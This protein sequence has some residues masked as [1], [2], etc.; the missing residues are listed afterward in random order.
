MLT[1][2]QRVLLVAGWVMA[3]AVTSLVASAAVAVAGGQVND[4][5]LTKVL[6][7]DVAALPVVD[8]EGDPCNE[9]LASGGFECTTESPSAG[10]QDGPGSGHEPDLVGG[11][12][13]NEAADLVGLDPEFPDGVTPAID[14]GGPEEAGPRF[15]I[16]TATEVITIGGG[17]VSFAVQDGIIRVLWAIPQYGYTTTFDRS[18]PTAPRI[19]FARGDLKNGAVAR[20]ED[21][22][23]VVD[24]FESDSGP[25][26]R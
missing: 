16:P 1:M 3:A 9:P 11:E 13:D 21:D 12:E 26:R 6:A 20:W 15:F 8:T 25:D 7:A 14:A 4:R 24:T 23:L 18:D 19:T 5:P 17:S 22:V 10:A 2:R